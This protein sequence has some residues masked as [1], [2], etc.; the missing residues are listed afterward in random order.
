MRHRLPFKRPVPVSYS[1]Q[2]D[3]QEAVVKRLKPHAKTVESWSDII[4][5]VEEETWQEHKEAIRQCALKRWLEILRHLPRTFSLVS[6]L[7]SFKE[8]GRQLRF[9]QDLL[10]NRSPETMLK[11]ANSFPKTCDFL[12]RVKELVFLLKSWTFTDCCALSEMQMLL[13]R[14]SRATW[15]R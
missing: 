10:S 12:R 2:S 5:N 1:S 6:D 9:L 11:R 8:V 13:H 4:K 7:H 14:G 3:S 15:R